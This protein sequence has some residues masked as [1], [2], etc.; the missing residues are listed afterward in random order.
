MP[1]LTKAAK[2]LGGALGPVRPDP[3]VWLPPQARNLPAAIQRPLAVALGSV[4]GLYRDG[5]QHWA[6]AIAYYG[7]LSIFPLLLS[8]A[9]VAAFFVDRQT[10]VRMVGGVLGQ[11][12]PHGQT[13]VVS[14][15]DEAIA[16]R[17][18]VTAI[19]L[20]FLLLSGL[21]V[22]GMLS[23]GLDMAFGG[24]RDPVFG[25]GLVMNLL[26]LFTAGLLF[27]AAFVAEALIGFLRARLNALGADADWI[28][29][30]GYQM[31]AS[32]LLGVALLLTYKFLPRRPVRWRSAFIGALAVTLLTAAARPIFLTYL[33]SFGQ[34]S[35]IY[36][37]L[38]SII[39][40]LIWA[41]VLAMLVLYGGELAAAVQAAYVDC[42][43]IY[44]EIPVADE[45]A[46]STHP[47]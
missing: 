17:G 46:P 7:L 14:L 18:A 16:A 19:S 20:L 4:R 40:V 47:S 2:A 29:A 43:P 30:P 13:A 38:A 1:F 15:V 33:L 35:L 10:A 11:Y 21:R 41:W 45:P 6:A 31:A 23:Q 44:A 39:V 3:R 27:A 22:F 36:G 5:A 42:V 24:G 25:R 28:I 26:M 37:S 9:S 8:A 12:L 34:L 32:L